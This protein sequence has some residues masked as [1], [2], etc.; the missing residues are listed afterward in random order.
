MAV[1]ACESTPRSQLR[2]PSAELSKEGWCQSR[3]VWQHVGLSAQ[4]E[5]RDPPQFDC[6]ISPTG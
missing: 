5:L 2:L 3:A 6:D 1:C 4:P